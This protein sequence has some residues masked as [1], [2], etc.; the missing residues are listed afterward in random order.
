MVLIFF[1]FQFIHYMYLKLFYLIVCAICK[2]I[3][4]FICSTLP[5]NLKSLWFTWYCTHF[6]KIGIVVAGGGFYSY[7]FNQGNKS[8]KESKIVRKQF[9][10]MHSKRLNIFFLNGCNSVWVQFHVYHLIPRPL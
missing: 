9:D 8:D 10:I 3:I 6:L 7:I 4:F 1:R 2:F 5:I